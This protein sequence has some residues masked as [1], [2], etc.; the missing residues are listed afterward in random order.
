M[1]LLSTDCAASKFWARVFDP[2]HKP[3][4]LRLGY[5]VMHVTL[6]ESRYIDPLCRDDTDMRNT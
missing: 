4:R 3:N 2:V 5:N 1:Q 6:S